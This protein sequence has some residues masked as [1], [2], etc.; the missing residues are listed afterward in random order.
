MPCN[1]KLLRALQRSGSVYISSREACSPEQRVKT[2]G[3][4]HSADTLVL[5]AEG[6]NL[7]GELRTQPSR[8]APDCQMDAAVGQLVASGLASAATLLCA[9]LLRTAAKCA[10]HMPLHPCLTAKG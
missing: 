9:S 1:S 3:L 6:F 7:F 10:I 5:A 4:G 2:V 8:L